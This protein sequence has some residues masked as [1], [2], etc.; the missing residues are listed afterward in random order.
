MSQAAQNVG[1]HAVPSVHFGPFELNMETGELRKHGVRVRLQHRPFQI[2]AALVESPGRLVTREELRTRLWSSD[3]FVDFESGLNTAVNRLRLT[4]GDSAENPVY[5]ETLS[6]LGYRFLAPVETSYEESGRIPEAAV[7]PASAALPAQVELAPFPRPS[8][9]VPMMLAAFAMVLILAAITTALAVRANR[10]EASFDRL[11]FRK[12]FVSEARFLPK[13]GG[14][15]FSAEWNGSPSRLFSLSNDRRESKD[16]NVSDAWLAGIA[17][18][19]EFGFFVRPANGEPPVLQVA[20]LS[21]GAPRSIAG[22]VRDA[23]W[24]PN[25]SLCLLTA[26][27][28]TYTI[29][30]PPGHK[31]YQSSQWI[32]DLRVSPNGGQV[33]FTEHPVPMDDGGHV[34]VVNSATSESRILGQG[35]ESLEG[36]AW[37]PSGREIWFTAARSGVEKSLWAVNLEGETRLVSQTPGGL[38]LRDI[39]PSG[40]A[41]ITRGNQHMTMLLG[42]FSQPTEQ[43]IS[44]LDWSRAAAISADG[45]TMLF[46]E[47]GSG[48]GA[49]YTLFIYRR[50]SSS[51]ERIGSGR[52]MDL[53]SDGR[54]ALAQDAADPTKLTVVSVTSRTAKPIPSDGFIYRWSKFFPDAEE[55]LSAGHFPGKSDGIYRQRLTEAPRLVNSRLQLSDAVI[56]PTGH[57]ATGV[58]DKCEIT[59]FSLID[60]SARTISIAKMAYPVIFLNASQILT[61]TAGKK[62]ITLDLLDTATGQLKPF[63][64]IEPSDPIGIS[65]TF[66]IQV[67][68]NLQT[69]VYSRLFSYSD[70]FIVSGLR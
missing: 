57:F 58:S 12:G 70:L 41:L 11:T 49:A 61:R 66:P 48:G 35:W 3:V 22:H 5:V 24:G 42:D 40:N 37:N 23:A 19:T 28:T 33:A 44:W 1:S 10:R 17:S 25:G 21:G 8:R 67:A 52:A 55:V 2:L 54:S 34:T 51:P 56:E 69:Y 20:P 31:L 68:R 32:S 30:Y 47:S 45:N 13:S 65:H 46:D 43:D 6:R 62:A 16:L 14:I 39:A 7:P 50:G 18:P 15:L 26:S 9:P 63:R 60:G 64:E 36:L 38:E 53:S 4:L 27:G 59:I 29:Q